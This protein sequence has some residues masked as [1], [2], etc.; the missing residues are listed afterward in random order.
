MPRT[1]RASAAQQ[2]RVISS[3]REKKL[4]NVECTAGLFFDAKKIVW[5]DWSVE[6][7]YLTLGQ[8]VATAPAAAAA[9]A[10][11]AGS[12][13][14]RNKKGADKG[15]DKKMSSAAAQQA[16]ADEQHAIKQLQVC[17]LEPY[18]CFCVSVSSGVSVHVCVYTTLSSVYLSRH[19]L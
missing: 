7:Q 10:P 9:A 14:K 15:T 3:P 1:E 13:K 5:G 18:C 19:I 12:G 17:C 11:P 16:A 8:A 4:C 6:S 2:A